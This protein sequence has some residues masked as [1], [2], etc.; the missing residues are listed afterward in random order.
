MGENLSKNLEK[1]AKTKG[2]KRKFESNTGDVEQEKSR[3]LR[4]LESITNKSARLDMDAAVNKQIFREDQER[5]TEKEKERDSKTK[6][7]KQGKGKREKSH[8]KNK[9]GKGKFTGKSAGPNRAA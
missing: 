5:K 3:T 9:G 4:V 6:N 7:K 1:S 2:N 8:F